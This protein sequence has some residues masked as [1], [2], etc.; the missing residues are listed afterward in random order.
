MDVEIDAAQDLD[1]AEDFVM[2][3]RRRIGAPLI[4]T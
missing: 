3:R 4:A 2:P 1:L